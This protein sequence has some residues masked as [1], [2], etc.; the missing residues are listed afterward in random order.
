MVYYTLGTSWFFA[1][2]HGFR[3]HFLAYQ[4]FSSFFIWGAN[5]I[6]EHRL[7]EQIT[8]THSSPV[9]CLNIN[10]NNDDKQLIVPLRWNVN[11]ATNIVS[12]FLDI[13][14]IDFLTWIKMARN[15]PQRM[16]LR[17]KTMHRIQY[18]TSQ[19]ESC[20]VLLNL[21]EGNPPVASRFPSQS[22]GDWSFGF[23]YLL[24]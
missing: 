12:R 24:T 15:L 2:E 13:K 23:I 7:H 21:C 19:K 1:C 6:Y 22:T 4:H 20:F 10:W 3:I 8:L 14:Y 17:A 16:V 5:N 18:R 9:R 11:H